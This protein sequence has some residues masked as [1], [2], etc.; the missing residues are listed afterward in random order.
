MKLPP[1]FRVRQR[2]DATRVADI[3]DETRRRLASLASLRNVAPGQRVA[4]TV[5]S[6]GIRDILSIIQSIVRYFQ[7]VGA[8]PFLV[9][10]MGS[11]GGGTVEGQLRLLA[12]YGITE[13]TCGCPILAT[14]DTVVVCQTDEGFPVHFD[15]HAFAADH[16]F[17]CNRIKP[18]TDF[19]GE[20]QSGLMKMMLIGLGNH[21]G[22]KIYHRA[23]QDHSF[24]QIVRSVAKRVLEHCRIVGGLAILENGYDQT[25][26]LV[27]IPPDQLINREP[28]LLRRA[29]QLMP[30][31]PFDVVDLLIVDEIGKNISGTGLDTNVVGRKFHGHTAADDEFPKIKRIAIRS[32]TPQTHGNACGIGVA[33]FCTSRALAQIDHELTR[34]NCLT[35]G[36][37]AVAM[38]PLDYP[39]DRQVF[40]HA[41][42]TI[43]LREPDAARI[44]WIKNTLELAEVECSA[45]Y[46]NA[47]R[48]RDDLEILSPLRDWPLDERGDL[49]SR[50]VFWLVEGP[51]S[52]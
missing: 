43:G 49:P 24:D 25:A 51:D 27:A 29:K 50:G 33:E 22:A 13:S 34:T 37:I 14:M 8:E 15:R 32:L 45:A 47:A 42:P 35:S 12:D 9:P 5:G 48:G 40:E 17:L 2:F 11:H 16:V 4:I 21:H 26:E 23:I 10:A 18:H 19:A 41:L 3:A 39:S 1:I 7:S 44:L 46:L 31:L 52:H 20:I 38:L 28:E 6:R 30:R 36:R